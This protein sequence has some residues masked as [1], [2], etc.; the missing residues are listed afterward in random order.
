MWRWRREK[1][2]G[3]HLASDDDVANAR[4]RPDDLL[5]TAVGRAIAPARGRHAVIVLVVHQRFVIVEV[6]GESNI[7]G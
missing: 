5:H 2:E 3:T 7:L 6:G 4:A 1:E